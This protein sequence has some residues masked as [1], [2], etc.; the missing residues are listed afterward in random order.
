VSPFRLRVLVIAVA[1]AAAGSGDS[2]RSAEIAVSVPGPSD[3]FGPTRSALAEG[4]NLART[5]RR[6]PSLRLSAELSKVAQDRAATVA[7]ERHADPDASAPKDS[8]AASRLGYEARLA[9]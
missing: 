6:L 5:E 3:E 8:A 4:I 2:S 1:A 9:S 7:A